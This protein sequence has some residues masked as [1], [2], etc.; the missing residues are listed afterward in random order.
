MN[1][2]HRLGARITKVIG[3]FMT[4]AFVFVAFAHGQSCQLLPGW[5]PSTLADGASRTGYQIPAATYTQSCADSV[6][7]ITCVS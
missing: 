6:G 4:I 7:I 1:Y 2:T 3:S 5:N